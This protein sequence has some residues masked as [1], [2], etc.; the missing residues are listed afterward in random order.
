[1]KRLIICIFCLFVLFFCYEIAEKA[2]DRPTSAPTR[3]EAL[4]PSVFPAEPELSVTQ[5]NTPISSSYE[6]QSIV[7]QTTTAY[8]GYIT[9]DGSSNTDS[10]GDWDTEL[11]LGK[12]LP[13]ICI[14]PGHYEGDNRIYGEKSYGYAEGDFTLQVALELQKILMEKY[15]IES[16]V[17]RSASVINLPG[18][19]IE[20]M[21]SVGLESRVEVAME[22]DCDF[23][24]S[25]HT[26]ANLPDA[27]QY[28]TLLQP[29]QITKTI[30]LVNTTC[31]DDARWMAVAN[32]V[33]KNLSRVNVE[34]GFAEDRPFLAG[35]PG[36]VPEWTDDWNDSLTTTGAVLC[37]HGERGDYYGLLRCAAENGLPGVI[38]EHG[39]HTVPEMRNAAM[40][41]DLAQRWAE[42]DADGIA[43]GLGIIPIR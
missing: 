31:C 4:L 18:Y 34:E 25:I 9:V 27:N 23:L 37:R 43:M 13:K 16:C 15:R 5:K 28:P 32:E 19:T 2:I 24:F 17:T 1:M 12:K 39:F 6:Q 7:S 22:Q 40:N 20:D 33:G 8:E 38:V 42:A 30:V 11:P 26:N 10:S 21:G 29:I 36:N 14:D 35:R 3:Q 41:G